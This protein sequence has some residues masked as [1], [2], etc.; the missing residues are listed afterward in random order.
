[1][2]KWLLVI[3]AFELR[4]DGPDLPRHPDKTQEKH[5]Q[6]EEDD[7]HEWMG[8]PREK[9][10]RQGRNAHGPKMDRGLAGNQVLPPDKAADKRVDKRV[11]SPENQRVRYWPSHMLHVQHRRMARKHQ[12]YCKSL[13]TFHCSR[14]VGEDGDSPDQARLG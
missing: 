12:H 3:N 8:Q 2:G 7:P 11:D 10:L 14:L 13:C 4:V 1:M 9:S 6:P 5:K